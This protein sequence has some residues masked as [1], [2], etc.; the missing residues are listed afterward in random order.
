MQLH[1]G[2]QHR[3]HGTARQWRGIFPAHGVNRRRFS[4]LGA[5]KTSDRDHRE[6]TH[7]AKNQDA[8][9]SLLQ[10]DRVEKIFGMT[11][12]DL[13]FGGEFKAILETDVAQTS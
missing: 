13:S 5:E 7:A 9:A 8:I 6:N 4:S 3:F 12:V 2:L 1:L 11:G 10:H